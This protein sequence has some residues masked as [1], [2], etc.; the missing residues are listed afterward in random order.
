MATLKVA[1]IP[2]HGRS[3]SSLMDNCHE[4]LQSYAEEIQELVVR[5][6]NEIPELRPIRALVPVSDSYVE[7]AVTAEGE[8]AA[9]ERYGPLSY[10]LFT[11]QD[12]AIEDCVL[13]NPS[14]ETRLKRLVALN[15]LF[16]QYHSCKVLNLGDEE[17]LT[18]RIT[19][20]R[21]LED[22]LREG[23]QV[24]TVSKLDRIYSATVKPVCSIYRWLAG[25]LEGGNLS[26]F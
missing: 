16:W 1:R 22:S 13:I 7:V 17:W 6:E 15:F 12:P 23:L 21:A 2:I 20:I 25:D 8:N 3:L 11:D 4:N 10:E 26:I 24:G 5:L 9:Y 18:T 19:E 14:W